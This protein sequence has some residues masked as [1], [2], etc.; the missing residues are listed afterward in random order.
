MTL[1]SSARCGRTGGGVSPCSPVPMPS[2]GAARAPASSRSIHIY[3]M[4]VFTRESVTQTSRSRELVR[5]EGAQWWTLFPVVQEVFEPGSNHGADA[6]DRHRSAGDRLGHAALDRARDP[7]PQR[8][9]VVVFHPRAQDEH[10]RALL[11]LG[12]SHI[13][14]VA[15][16]RHW[17]VMA[18]GS[19]RL[20]RLGARLCG[21]ANDLGKAHARR[22]AG[23]STT[24]HSKRSWRQ[25]GR[26]FPGARGGRRRVARRRRARQ[27][28]R[29]LLVVAAGLGLLLALLPGLAWSWSRARR[30]KRRQL[31]AERRDL[32]GKIAELER[33]NAA[34]RQELKRTRRV[35]TNA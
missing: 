35:A 19:D 1:R 22:N 13:Y 10:S 16:H 6:F 25:D 24:S 31:R 29:Q 12:R 33:D 5:S 4:I 28:Q 23:G 15:T 7:H 14:S 34:L 2:R 9:L 3:P 18:D 27:H 30:A 21:E 26:T 20:P 8:V 11:R 17:D 32:E